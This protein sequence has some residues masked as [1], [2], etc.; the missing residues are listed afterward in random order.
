MKWSGFATWETLANT[1]YFLIQYTIIY[2]KQKV[3]I[4]K[5][6]SWWSASCYYCISELLGSGRTNETFMLVIDDNL[7][8][9]NYAF[10]L[11]V[12]KYLAS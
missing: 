12:H 7:Q 4:T 1:L 9:A 5:Q 8:I 2:N 10:L 3:V 11:F 6:S